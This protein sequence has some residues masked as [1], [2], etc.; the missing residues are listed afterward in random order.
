MTELCAPVYH[1]AAYEM[2]QTFVDAEIQKPVVV[3]S[4][5]YC[6]FCKLA[7]DVL[8]GIGV[9]YTLHELDERGRWGLRS[10]PL[11]WWVSGKRAFYRCASDV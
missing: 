7:T 5:S 8:A 1:V 2:A 9:Q 11:L 4:K 3:F 10:F 6:P